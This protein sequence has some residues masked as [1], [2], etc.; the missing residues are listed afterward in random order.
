MKILGSGD[1]TKKLTVSTTRS[2]SRLARR[3]RGQAVASC[4]CASRRSASASATR[5]RPSRSRPRSRRRMPRSKRRLRL[6]PSRDRALRGIARA[7]LADQRVARARAAAARLL[8]TAMIIALY[9]LGSWVPAPGVDRSRSR[10]TSRRAGAARCWACSTSSPAG[11]SRSSP[12]FALGIMPYVGVDHPPVADRR[13]ALAR[14]APER[15]EAGYAN[16]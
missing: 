11:R 8:F 1:L 4:S 3:S 7:H 14:A 5:R 16:P 13:H 12:C 15:G 10:T 2:P 9:Q 6:T